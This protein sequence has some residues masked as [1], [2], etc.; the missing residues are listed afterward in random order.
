MS[1]GTRKSPSIYWQRLHHTFGINPVSAWSSSL[2]RSVRLWL[3]A[4]V[5]GV[6]YAIVGNV[7]LRIVLLAVCCLFFVFDSLDCF[8]CC[9]RLLLSLTVVC[10]SAAS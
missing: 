7:I 5:L 9:H 8:S 1:L 4:I 2:A 10:S 6:A 3:V